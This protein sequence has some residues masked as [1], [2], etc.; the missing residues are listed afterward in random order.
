[1][2]RADGE[3]AN[4]LDEL[5]QMDAADARSVVES[6]EPE[7]RRQVTK[8][9]DG[10]RAVPR[11]TGGHEDLGRKGLSGWLNARLNAD[12]ELTPATRQALWEAAS[13]LP[14]L[15]TEAAQH[16]RSGAGGL[17]RRLAMRSTPWKLQP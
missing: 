16:S 1:M 2:R 15:A 3:L 4:M 8:M 10:V 6:L 9:L 5:S 14:D 13:Q 12:Q 11:R 17:L 7:Q